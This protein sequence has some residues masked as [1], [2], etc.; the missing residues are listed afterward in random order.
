MVEAGEPLHGLVPS[1]SDTAT[2]R[3]P[4]AHPLKLGFQPGA[5]LLRKLFGKFHRL[6]E[7][8]GGNASPGK[9]SLERFVCSSR[10]GSSSL[11]QFTTAEA[12]PWLT[13]KPRPSALASE[14]VPSAGICSPACTMKRSPFPKAAEATSVKE[15]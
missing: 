3:R 6:V 2:T 5:F 13:A 8:N 10:S 11:I 12:T 4:E 1:S 15:L 7:G 9:S 14:R